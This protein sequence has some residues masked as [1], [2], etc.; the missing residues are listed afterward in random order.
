MLEVIKIR[1]CLKSQPF[2][3]FYLKDKG[4]QTLIISMKAQLEKVKG[5]VTLLIT[6]QN[7]QSRLRSN[8]HQL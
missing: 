6:K 2:F 8:R 4:T 5:D 7:Q 1:Y 3:N